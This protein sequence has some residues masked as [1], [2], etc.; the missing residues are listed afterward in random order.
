MAVFSLFSSPKP[1]AFSFFSRSN[2]NLDSFGNR[3][4]IMLTI[5]MIAIGI[6][7]ALFN[8]ITLWQFLAAGLGGSVT[9]KSVL[10]TMIFSL[11][12]IGIGSAASAA[13]NAP[14]A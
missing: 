9:L 1:S 12:G 4:R 2:E 7:A 14:R 8:A 6:L 13:L 5:S 3:T 10:S 11:V